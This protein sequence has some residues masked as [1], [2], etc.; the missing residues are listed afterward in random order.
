MEQIH[1]GCV[2]DAQLILEEIIDIYHPHCALPEPKYCLKKHQ[3]DPHVTILI[4]SDT[5][6]SC[7]PPRLAEAPYSSSSAHT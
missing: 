2:E 7:S 1:H 5:F 6:V 3:S 4:P